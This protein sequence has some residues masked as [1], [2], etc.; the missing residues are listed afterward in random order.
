[1]AR[2]AKRDYNKGVYRLLYVYP[3]KTKFDL[4][5]THSVDCDPN[6]K[7]LNADFVFAKEI[8]WEQLKTEI[9]KNKITKAIWFA[10]GEDGYVMPKDIIS[11][12]HI[13]VFWVNDDIL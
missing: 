12:K 11:G 4:V 13:G 5:L 9:K 2:K 7:G 1:M 3:D 8:D 6:G 10:R